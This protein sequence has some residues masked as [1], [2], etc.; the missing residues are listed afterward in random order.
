MLHEWG[1]MGILLST[2]GKHPRFT[3]IAF[4]SSGLAWSTHLRGSKLLNRVFPK[5][6]YPKPPPRQSRLHNP[7]HRG[8]GCRL[9]T[10][11][12]PVAS[13]RIEQRQITSR[14]LQRASLDLP[15]VDLRK[16]RDGMWRFWPHPQ[17]TIVSATCNRRCPPPGEETR[18]WISPVQQ[19]RHCETLPT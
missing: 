3:V 1:T 11:C 12:S 4:C 10:F 6:K 14:K 8:Q 9:R 15:S 19:G 13:R 7:H 2:A 18:Q 16:P 5:E 17:N